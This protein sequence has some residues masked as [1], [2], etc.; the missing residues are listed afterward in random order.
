MRFAGHGVPVADVT[1]W[2][3]RD[4]RADVRRIADRQRRRR[5]VFRDGRRRPDRGGQSG[6]DQNVLGRARKG[7]AGHKSRRTAVEGL[8]ESEIG[9]RVTIS[10]DVSLRR[11]TRSSRAR[12]VCVGQD[13]RT[14]PGQFVVISIF[15]L[16]QQIIYMYTYSDGV[17]YRDFFEKS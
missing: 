11:R 15:R 5:Q 10:G 12:K 13:H 1:P 3:K 6:E 2:R 9:C 7:P 14:L 16:L 4:G 17:C 8:G